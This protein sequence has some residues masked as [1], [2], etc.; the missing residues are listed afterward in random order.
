MKDFKK[1]LIWQL[2]MDIVNKVYDVTVFLPS[3]EKYG[4]R[5]PMTRSASSIPVNV[6]E[7]SAK[8][9]VKE[10]IKYIEIS[11]GS[12]FELETHFLIVQRR[13]WVKDEKLIQELLEMVK[14]GQR[15]LTKFIEKI[16]A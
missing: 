15:M 6:A 9:S 13:G 3:E 5:S 1:L 7:G 12:A 4:I 16:E 2:G 10:H 8:R 14:H 11:L